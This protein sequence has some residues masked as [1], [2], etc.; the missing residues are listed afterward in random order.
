MARVNTFLHSLAVGQVDKRHLA[1]VDLSRMR[2]AAEIQKNILPLTTGPAFGRPGLEYLGTT[3]SN[4]A[5]RLKEFVFGVTDAVLMEFTNNLMRIWVDDALVTRPSVSASVTQGSFSADS[6]WTKTATDGATVT[7][8]GGYLNLTAGAKGSRASASQSVSVS[9]T[10]TEHALRVVIDRGP[11]NIRVGSTSGGDEYINETALRTGTHSLA[12]T[13]TG[14]FYIEFFS[15][16]QTLKRVDS[17]TVEG[18][19]VMTVPTVWDADDLYSMRFAQS[20]DVVFV[21]CDGYKPQRI[22]RRSNRSWS[23]VDYTPDSGPFTA[24]RT[25]EVKLT[26]SVTESNG[27]LTASSA[28]FNSNHVGTLFSLFHEGFECTTPLASGGEYTEPFLVTGVKDEVGDEY[29]DR[30]WTY[31]ITGTWVGTIRWERSF[32]GEFGGYKAF[33]KSIS[34]ALT[35]ITSNVTNITNL[36]RDDNAEIWYR[37]GFAEDDYTSGTATIAVDYDGGGGSGY[38]RVTGYNSP[39]SVSIEILE[40][41]KGSTG[42]ADWREGEWSNNRVWPSAVTFA[43]GRLWWSGYDR[44][45]GSVSDDYENFDDEVE[46]DSGPISRSIATGGV[47]T[48]QWLLA[49]QKLLVGTNGA[50]ATCK[51]SS[52]DEPITPTN[53]SIKD[54]SSTGAANV[55]PVRIDARGIFVERSGKALME[56]T[57]DGSATDYNATQ[58]SKLATDLFSAGVKTM[59]VQRRPDTRIWVV[60]NDG[61]CV[62]VVYEPLEEVLAFIPIETDGNFESV[63]VL[64]A[65]DQDRVYFVVNRTID[66]S[67]VRYIEKMAKDSEVAPSTTC[68]VMD[69]FASG[70][71]A[72]A[73]TTINVGTHLEGESVVVWADGAPLTASETVNGRVYENPR[74]FTVNAS[75]NITVPSAVTDW[76]AGLP[77]TARY[78][79]ARLA[80]GAQGG[81][82]M[83]QTK[84][85]TG[86]GL[87]LTDYVREGL[88]YGSEFDNSD[89]PLAMLPENAGGTTA[90]S[91]VDGSVTEEQPYMFE[92][93]WDTDSRV[94]LEWQS[95]FTA[96]VMGMVYGIDTNEK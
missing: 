80:Y 49:L 61:S 66:S 26:P 48:T 24:T 30:E 60:M 76:V 69:S 88:R 63:A 65:T 62:C 82:A 37:I 57:Y 75:G 67:T 32:D 1:R 91:V 20:A 45:W 68:K 29:N 34:T 43:E 52:L 90:T 74:T 55:D 40:P 85:V 16:K 59:A 2:L 79:S 73:S 38:A 77:Y 51:S 50:V 15:K 46:G 53:L 71:N 89:R 44:L 23:V 31:T 9:E 41:F 33:R 94:C 12:F 56:L 42:T 5:A 13:P 17:C 86:L 10:G 87:I 14:T 35:D 84:K 6:G 95:P 58:L 81:T 70:T 18:S 78:K 21:A 64:P 36:D 28:F 93:V 11:V 7:I 72:P 4:N 22:E 3:G 19:G 39:T 54:S 27:T 96:T 8:S 47:N 92:G 25:R 83:L